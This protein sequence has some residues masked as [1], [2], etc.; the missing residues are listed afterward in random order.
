[1]GNSLVAANVCHAWHAYL[2]IYHVVGLAIKPIRVWNSQGDG[3]Q[4]T[5]HIMASPVFIAAGPN[6]LMVGHHRFLGPQ[7]IDLLTY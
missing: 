2:T 6:D 7:V 5:N 3:L 1:M 4:V